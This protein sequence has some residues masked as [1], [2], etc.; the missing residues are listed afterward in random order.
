MRL[1]D[2]PICEIS[3]KSDNGKV[4]KFRGTSMTDLRRWRNRFTRQKLYFRGDSHTFPP[5]FDHFPIVRF[6]CNFGYRLILQPH[7]VGFHFFFNES[8]YRPVCL[9]TTRFSESTIVSEGFKGG[10]RGSPIMPRDAVSRTANVG[11]VGINGLKRLSIY[12][13]GFCIAD[14]VFEINLNLLLINYPKYR[15]SCEQSS[16]IMKINFQYWS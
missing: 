8:R 6:G 11:T 9:S 12:P 14:S 5:K 7:F 13:M 16:Y 15:A 3:S 1:Q 2:K 4:V 10:T